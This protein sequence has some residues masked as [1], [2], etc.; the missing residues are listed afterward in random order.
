MGVSRVSVRE[1]MTALRLQGIVATRH[2]E[3]SVVKNT[4][5]LKDGLSN[6]LLILHRETLNPFEIFVVREHIEPALVGLAVE[7]ATEGQIALIEHHLLSMK[8]AA[9]E[10]DMDKCFFSNCRFHYSIIEATNNDVAIA[11]LNS[12]YQIMET[13]YE[14]DR[15]WHRIISEYHCSEKNCKKCLLGHETILKAIVARDLSAA[16][17][18]YVK[19]FGDM[20][21]SLFMT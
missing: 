21:S 1:A 17:E 11:M 6:S 10:K 13:G 3:G 12:I 5:R 4:H 2:G 7:N 16:Q 19:H 20:H 15:L 9:K 18:S 14:E 8:A